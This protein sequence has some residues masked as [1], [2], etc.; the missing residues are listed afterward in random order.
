MRIA[1]PHH[2]TK[3]AARSKL[4]ERLDQFLSQFGADIGDIEHRWMGDVLEFKGKAKGFSVAGTVEVTDA[5]VI[6]DG[7]LPLIAR[8]FEG[9]IRQAVEAEADAM[10]RA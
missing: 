8:P 6:I 5:A 4:Q 7:K 2:T 10:F 1:I 9:R 3:A